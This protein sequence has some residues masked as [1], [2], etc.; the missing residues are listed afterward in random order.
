MTQLGSG[1]DEQNIFY[2]ANPP[3]GTNNF[4]INWDTS[5]NPTSGPTAATW[6]AATII[7]A[8]T[9]APLDDNQ[10][11][12]APS[13]DT[14]TWDA[15]TNADSLILVQGMVKAGSTTADCLPISGNNSTSMITTIDEDVSGAKGI[16]AVGEKCAVAGTT[17]TGVDFNPVCPVTGMFT[18]IAINAATTASGCGDALPGCT[19]P[20]GNPGDI[21]Y[22]NTNHVLTY[23]NG[24]SWV[25]TGP[26]PGSGPG[27]PDPCDPSNSPS[28]GQACNDGSVYAGLSP[29]GNVAMYTTPADQGQFPWNDGNGS[30]FVTTNQTSTVTGETNTANLITIDSDFAA[31]G[32]QPHRAA[33]ACADLTAHG[34]SDWYL[35]A[36]DEINVLYTNNAAIGGFNTSGSFPAG[37]YWSSTEYSNG[38]ARAQR[39]SSGIYLNYNKDENLSVR[40]VR[41]NYVTLSDCTNPSGDAGDLTYDTGANVMV[42]CNG[43]EWVRIGK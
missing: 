42:Y 33:Q 21:V 34:H 1:T 2:L 26:M 24:S 30:G 36:E 38:P 19:S 41:K 32:I 10:L 29:D 9:A 22:D 25:A 13:N 39:F 27:S 43:S 16:A 3:N 6:W 40:C 20:A 11:T 18:G 31:S 12:M 28:P 37:Y 14:I 7:N 17:T 8:D 4:A 15:S 23:C 5:M 35:P